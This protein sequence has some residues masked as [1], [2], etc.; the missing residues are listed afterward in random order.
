[1]VMKSS[2]L[3]KY[4][5]LEKIGEGTYGVVYKAK[6]KQT[7]Q[8]YALKKI[9]LESEDEGIP[10]TAIREISLLKE[11]Q[12]INVVKLHDVIHSNK[13]LILVF[14]FVAQ[15][16]KKFMVGF[17]ET[18]LD[19][20]VVKS[21]L[22]QLLKG[23]EI[24][25]KNKIL[26]RDL[27][28]QNLLISDD[29]ILKLAD[30][31][32]ARASGIP[33]KNYTHEVVTLWY[34]PPDV[35]L[36]SKNY[37][38]SID[39][40]SVGCIF[41]EMVNLKALFP[42]NS[43]SD[44]LKKSLRLQALLMW[45]NGLAQLIYQDGNIFRYGKKL[46]TCSDDKLIKIWQKNSEG[47]WELQSS[48][49]T[50]D[51][52]VWKIKWA[53]PSFGIML[54]ACSIDR[55]VYI[56]EEFRDI[57]LNMNSKWKIT[58]L[59]SDKEQIED[60]K[61]APESLGL[62]LTVAYSDRCIRNFIFKDMI[63]LQL[64]STLPDILLNM[65]VNCVSWNKNRFEPAMIAIGC[66]E[67]ESKQYNRD[68]IMEIQQNCFC[69]YIQDEKTQ[70]FKEI[71]FSNQEQTHKQTVNDVS[72]SQLNGRSFHLIATCGK[73]GA[74]I[75]YLQYKQDSMQVLQVFDL[76]GFNLIN[77][78]VQK[79]SWNIMG[80]LLATSDSNNDITLYKSFG[81]GQWKMIKSIEE[82]QNNDK[83]QK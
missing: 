37:S 33:V 42:G 6:D 21:L 36:G 75:W 76:S 68:N 66:K 60:I 63:N 49:Q 39:I 62:V 35:L 71:K 10:S 43:D 31:G 44:Q 30:F 24:C 2:K 59:Q 50:E 38:T 52:P 56:Y 54:A 53:H 1:M 32:L 51:G 82:S 9:R 22:Y 64:Y 17:K 70:S 78:E 81:Y 67:Q 5:K 28:P 19:A 25:H 27:K 14:E 12:H 73:E 34:R 80:S 13:K 15:D 46:A 18:G 8:L 57:T 72:W 69:I 29:G 4:E 3:D 11:L 47:G 7:N 74:K 65:P 26:H 58:K 83:N 55:S 77:A 40:W 23:I 48:I 79:I 41:A 61:F 16:L 20:K 45:N